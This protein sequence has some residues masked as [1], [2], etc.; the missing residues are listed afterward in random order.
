MP[1]SGLVHRL[2]ADGCELVELTLDDVRPDGRALD[3]AMTPGRCDVREILDLVARLCDAVDYAHQRGVLHRD[4]KPSNIILDGRGEPRLLDFGLAKAID[5][6]SQGAA[7]LTLSEPGQI[8]G[9]LA[10][11]P[12]EQ[13]RGQ[14][15]QLSVRTDVYS[16]GAVAYELVTGKLPCSMDGT[17]SEVLRRI[18]DMDPAPPSSVR[19]PQLTKP[20]GKPRGLFL[21]SGEE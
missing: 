13:S 20:A 16:L 4:L 17:L 8:I 7:D 5:P 2:R 18:E 1:V 9:T 12:P 19:A 6:M 15:D 14:Y 21:W 10:F 11:M 3:D